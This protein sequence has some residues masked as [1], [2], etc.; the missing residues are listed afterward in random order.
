M[1]L[2]LNQALITAHNKRTVY[3]GILEQTAG[4]IFMGTPHRGSDA[5]K[6]ASMLKESLSIFGFG[7]TTHLASDLKRQSRTLMQINSDFVERAHDIQ[8]IL[9]F[10]ETHK[11][12]GLNALV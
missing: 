6:W 3:S 5:A 1:T 8:Q 4:L 10:Y 7:P 12:R 11:T 2:T 9:S